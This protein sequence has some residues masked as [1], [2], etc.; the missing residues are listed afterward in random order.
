M[1]INLFGRDIR[2]NV[3][4]FP[5]IMMLGASKTGKNIERDEE[6]FIILRQWVGM[7]SMMLI[8]KKLCSGLSSRFLKLNVVVLLHESRSPILSRPMEKRS[9]LKTDFL[10]TQRNLLFH[11]ISFTMTVIDWLAE[12]RKHASSKVGC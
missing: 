1:A 12:Y 5:S 9:L 4:G 2:E 10:S 8:T 3:R 11:I 7:E 6:S